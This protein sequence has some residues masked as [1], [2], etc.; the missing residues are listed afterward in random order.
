MTKAK[1]QRTAHLVLTAALAKAKR[2]KI[3]SLSKQVADFKKLNDMPSAELA[4]KVL[5]AYRRNLRIPRWFNGSITLPNAIERTLTLSPEKS[6]TP[7]QIALR[8]VERDY[9]RTTAPAKEL[10]VMVAIQLAKLVKAR[11]VKRVARGQYS[12]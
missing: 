2:D 11:K 1:K 3:A 9:F 5:T 8:M 12:R 4:Q 7:T 10:Q 6:L